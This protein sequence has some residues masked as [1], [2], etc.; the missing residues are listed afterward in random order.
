MK[1]LSILLN[2]Y[3]DSKKLNPEEQR[4]IDEYRLDCILEANCPDFTHPYTAYSYNLP[5]YLKLAQ[6]H[7]DFESILKKELKNRKLI[8]LGPGANPQ[9]E[10]ALKYGIKEYVGVEPFNSEISAKALPKDQKLSIEPCK[11]A[12]HYLLGVEESSSVVISMGMMCEE[13]YHFS[14]K[15][16]YK[17]LIKEI[18]RVTPKGAPTIH[19]NGPHNS[20]AEY[21]RQFGFK[22]LE[23]L[24][25]DAIFIKQ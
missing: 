10:W 17:F 5:I 20:F 8:E 25:G 1:D 23:G 11:E 7:T 12:L 21:F 22:A 19:I 24:L 6:S 18:A 15:D 3:F 14:N 13:V 2:K 16:Y 4:L 9:A